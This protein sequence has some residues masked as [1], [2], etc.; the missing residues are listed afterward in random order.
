MT[1]G[2]GYC[3]ENFII[4]VFFIIFNGQFRFSILCGL[5]SFA[6]HIWKCIYFS[7]GLDVFD[8]LHLL[9][10]HLV[11]VVKHLNKK[12]LKGWGGLSWLIVQGFSPSRTSWQQEGGSWSHPILSQDTENSKCLCPLGFL[13]F[14]PS[15]NC[16]LKVLYGV[17]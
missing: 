1:L 8:P 12:Q 16:I 6:L 4:A 2:F 11:A 15:L 9:V 13:L 3:E 17:L 10:I 14:T 5:I 7:E